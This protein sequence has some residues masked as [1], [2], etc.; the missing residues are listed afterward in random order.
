MNSFFCLDYSTPPYLNLDGRASLT[1][2][3]RYLKSSHGFKIGKTCNLHDRVR[4]FGVK[5]PFPIDFV[6]SGWFPDHRGC[7]KTATPEVCNQ[8]PGR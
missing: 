4:L 5:L 1:R 2:K 3:A 8:A 7:R 6:L